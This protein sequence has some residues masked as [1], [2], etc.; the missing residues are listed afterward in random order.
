G[1]RAARIDPGRADLHAAVAVSGTGDRWFLINATPDV[2]HQ[3]AAVPDLH[4]GPGV[5][6]TPVAGVLLTDAE[7]DH[8]IGLLVLREGASLTVF[9]TAP[10]LDTLTEHF[11]VRRLLRD[12]A[13]IDWQVIE[14]D[15]PFELDKTLTATPLAAGTKQP[16][17]ARSGGAYGAVVAYRLSDSRTGA[18]TVYAP[19]MSTWD[20]GIQAE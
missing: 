12:Y 11:P 5:R 2:A 13:D 9:G 10:V 14:P 16:R 4:P 15:T 8:T 6:E 3:I 20:E 1:C 18:V 19:G 7:F 17:Y